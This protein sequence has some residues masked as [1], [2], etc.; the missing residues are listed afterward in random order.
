VWV[1][2]G[3]HRPARAWPTLGHLAGLGV[4]RGQHVALLLPNVPQFTVA[5]FA[6]H[7]LRDDELRERAT[8]LVRSS[9]LTYAEI[10]AL[11]TK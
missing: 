11:T 7:V 3:N 5:Y 10:A 1:V 6:A 2:P 9:L 8:T 4:R